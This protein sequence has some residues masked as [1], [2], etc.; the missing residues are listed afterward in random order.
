MSEKKVDYIKMTKFFNLFD[1]TDNI[2]VQII[3]GSYKNYIQ[4]IIINYMC[5]S[6]NIDQEY[7]INYYRT[8]AIEQLKNIPNNY[9]TSNC[10][11]REIIHWLV[12]YCIYDKD[13][14]FFT[15][16]LQ[17]PHL[18]IKPFEKVSNKK[19]LFLY[20]RAFKLCL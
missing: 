7:D 10:V 11:Y 18:W 8:R 20:K 3:Y 19:E 1:D 9:F 16:Q 5:D 2:I 12:K 6:F 4:S 14:I 17:S 15:S 13:R